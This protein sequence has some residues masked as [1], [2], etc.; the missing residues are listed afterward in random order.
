M[1]PSVAATQERLKVVKILQ[2]L[3]GETI[4]WDKL[5]ADSRSFARTTW[6]HDPLPSAKE[7]ENSNEVPDKLEV[8]SCVH[9]LAAAL[10]HHL[11]EEREWSECTD[12]E[13]L[14]S[15]L[16]NLSSIVESYRLMSPGVMGTQV[17]THFLPH[18]NG[19]TSVISVCERLLRTPIPLGYNIA[20]SRILWI[21]VFA[22]PSQ[23]WGELGWCSV[24]VM[25]I[26]AYALFALAEAGLEIENNRSSSMN[27]ST[28]R[29]TTVLADVGIVYGT[30]D[31]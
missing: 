13:K 18:I 26:T 25:I 14:L 24:A 28:L 15:H 27:G 21:L 5:S 10:K 19:F 4:Q 7:T 12:L 29:S 17:L 1:L 11:R 16:P 22:L 23:L 9:I 8:T 20:V 2:P 6:L 30:F 31:W 3:V